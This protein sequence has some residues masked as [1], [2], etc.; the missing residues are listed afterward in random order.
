M[1]YKLIFFRVSKR[2][3]KAIKSCFFV[4][5]MNYILLL[6]SLHF[7]LNS[8]YLRLNKLFNQTNR[9]LCLFGNS[10]GFNL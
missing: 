6:Q 3:F 8:F 2:F 5:S 1:I 4:K 7:T 10:S 9:R